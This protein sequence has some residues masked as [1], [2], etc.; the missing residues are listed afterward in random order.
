MHNWKG[1]WLCSLFLTFGQLWNGILLAYPL[2]C[3]DEQGSYTRCTSISL[4]KLLDRAIQHAELLYRVSEESCT[5]FEDNF[6]PFSLVSQRSRNFNS[7]YT[8]GLRLPSSKSEAQQVSDK[9]LL[10][11]VLVLVQSWI[12]PFVYLQRT[13]DTYNSLP[14]SLVNKTK[15]VSD[16]LPSLEQGIVVLIRKMLHEGLI[17]TDFQQSVIEIEPSPEITDSSARDYM[18]LNCFRKDAHK[19]E[20]FLKLLKCRQIKKLNCY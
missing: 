3:K 9:W 2:D 1:V 8:K 13:L 5:I 12:E 18:I 19:M 7:C 16:K 20:T 17:T 6:A 10:H 14:G 4:E 15:W 11:S